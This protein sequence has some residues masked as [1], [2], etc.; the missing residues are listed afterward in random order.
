[1]KR[2][3]ITIAFVL[4]LST[5]L[6]A[7]YSTDW[8]RPAESYQKNGVMIARDNQDNVIA[9]GYWTSNN[10]YTRKYNRFG[11]LQ[12]EAIS[13]SGI[14]GNYERPFWVTTDNSNDV[15]VAG[16]RYSGVSTPNAL[17]VLKYSAD[18]IQL[19]K[20]IITPVNFL[21]GMNLRCLADNSGNL[22]V[23]ACG[24]GAL[25]GFALIKLDSNGNIVFVQ[26][27]DANAPKYFAS[28][29]LKANRVVL[30]SSSGNLSLAPVAVWDTAGTL[31]WTAAVTGRGGADVE[32]DDG[33][34]VY[35]LTGYDNQ[36]GPSTAMDIE[37]YKFNAAGT[38]LW[39][40]DF[41]FG[42]TELPARLTLV[43]GKLSIIAQGTIGASY[44][45]WV[46]MQTDAGGNMLWN[47]RYNGSSANDEVPYYVAAKANGEVFVTG[48]GGPSP[49]PSNLSY[50]RMITLKYNNS[51]TQAWIDSSN[52][53]SGWGY[54]CT[55]ASDSSLYVLSSTAMTAF[56]FLD[57]TGAG[58]CNIPTGLAVA[59]INNTFATF[60]WTA[61][62]GATLYHLRYKPV[63]AT[64]W[65]VVS[66][67]LTSINVFGLYAGTTYQY[68]VEAVC[69]NGPTGY[70]ATQTFTT[71]GTAVCSSAGQSQAQEYLSQVWL[72][73]G[74]NNVSGNNNGYADFT[75][76]SAPLTRNQLVQG[77][78]S[79]LVPFPEYEHYGIWIDYNH[80]NDFNDA[81]EDAV[82]LYTDFTGLISFNFTVPSGAPLGAARMR[83]VMSH[84]NPAAPCGVYARG[85][86]EDYTVI[87]NDGSTTP[88]SVPTGLN[89]FNIT[90]SGATFSWTPDA[91]AASYNLRYKRQTETTWTIAPSALPSIDI[92]GLAAAT[93]Y[94]YAVEAVGSAGRS[95]YTATQAFTT[96]GPILPITGLDLSAR[97][98]GANVLLSWTTMA[99]QNSARFDIER[100]VDGIHYTAVGQVPAAG[101]SASLRS[102]R[103]TDMDVAKSI[104]FYRLK[105]VDADGNYKLSDI[106]VVAK[107]DTDIQAFLLYPNPAVADV[108]IV[109]TKAAT[110][111][112][113]LQV[114]NQA[115]Q[116]VKTIRVNKG[117]QL[118]HMDV[119]KL[120]K[121]I[122]I[123]KLTGNQT[124]QVKKLVIH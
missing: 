81:G 107:A 63:T 76:I 59:N 25:P 24:V 70:G 21:A 115:G 55:L 29:R 69:N 89:V 92:P 116:V 38:Q 61:V 64:A 48:K 10:T 39:K 46:T 20:K 42:G 1:M 96:L 72:M 17:V 31:L 44:F 27:N 41:D 37:I 11:V 77:Y 88:P 101:Y 124:T 106:R 23:G 43:A 12:W 50:L 95:G 105:M 66:Y 117:W 15:Y 109:L 93:G 33:G 75:N 84:D 36:V 51:G 118:I 65:N 9:T 90:S 40:K 113:Q 67:N 73:S 4:L 114:I 102:Y 49:D 3:K 5:G 123:V 85:E 119:S 111:E 112:M 28:M 100:S 16:Y 86:T 35:L 32:M 94:D 54:A 62:P 80:D 122:Y 45:D 87:I 108:H 18:G 98:Q 82:T 74:F 47:A 13:A 19:W 91:T 120:G 22:Y 110:K 68:A 52:I 99:E 57:H 104:L 2:F 97:R 7:Q 56:H 83:V 14:A 53:Y 60:S 78:L 103:F 34:N 58:P 26:N 121:G 79:A 30:T 71:T 8:I 6:Q